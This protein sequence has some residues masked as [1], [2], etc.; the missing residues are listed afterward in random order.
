MKP[1]SRAVS[2]AKRVVTLP[3]VLVGTIYFWAKGRL[4]GSNSEKARRAAEKLRQSRTRRQLRG[5]PPD[6]APDSSNKRVGD[7]S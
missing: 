4:I 5:L 6:H 7:K 3:F 2:I 1:P